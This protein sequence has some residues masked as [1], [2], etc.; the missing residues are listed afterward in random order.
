MP[1]SHIKVNMHYLLFIVATLL[2]VSSAYS[3]YKI[4]K[5][6]KYIGGMGSLLPW[7]VF[8]TFFFI[9][10]LVFISGIFT[11]FVE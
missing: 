5:G 1:S 6:K 11:F 9:G 10:I 2:A 7:W 3:L 8:G 4:S